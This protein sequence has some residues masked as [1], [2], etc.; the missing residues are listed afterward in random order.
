[1]M[2]GQGGGGTVNKAVYEGGTR[3]VQY[4]VGSITYSA[5]GGDE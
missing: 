3:A 2:Q 1:M 4:P 5:Q